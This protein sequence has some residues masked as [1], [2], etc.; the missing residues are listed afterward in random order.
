M[1]K[2][3][4]T[5]YQVNT[6]IFDVTKLIKTVVYADMMHVSEGNTLMFFEQQEDG[7]MRVIKT[8]HDDFWIFAEEIEDENHEVILDADFYNKVGA[9]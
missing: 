4:V 1:R 2:Y 8:W 3:E 9:L 5:H 7:S 6:A